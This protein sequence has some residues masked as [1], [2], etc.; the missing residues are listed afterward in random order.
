MFDLL[1]RYLESFVVSW[2]HHQSC[3][4]HHLRLPPISERNRS[5]SMRYSLKVYNEDSIKKFKYL[6]RVARGGS[7]QKKFS[8]F[9]RVIDNLI[10]TTDY[11]HQPTLFPT[12]LKGPD[13]K[14]ERKWVTQQTSWKHKCNSKG[15]RIIVPAFE[16]E[17]H[18]QAL[19]TRISPT[20]CF[21]FWLHCSAVRAFYHRSLLCWSFFGSE[22]QRFN[23]E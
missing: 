23:S 8:T 1:K 19:R 17:T 15:N 18:F 13:K 21:N 20:L 12:L 3:E 11:I 10:C 7:R 6:F 5:D 9:V 14:S 2:S 16:R 22:S 4:S